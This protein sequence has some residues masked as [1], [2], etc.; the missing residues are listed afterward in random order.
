MAFGILPHA[1]VGQPVRMATAAGDPTGRAHRRQGTLEQ[2]LATEPFLAANFVGHGDHAERFHIGVV[3]ADGAVE[4]VVNVNLGPIGIEADGARVP[5]DADG[6]ADALR[7]AVVVVESLRHVHV[8]R[9]GVD[10]VELL[11]V[12]AQRRFPRVRDDVHVVVSIEGNRP[13]A[14]LAL[15]LLPQVAD[16]QLRENRPAG[17]E[18]GDAAADV[19]EVR[20]RPLRVEHDVAGQIVRFVTDPSI[21]DVPG[22]QTNRVQFGRE[23]L[24][25]KDRFLVGGQR[26]AP[27]VRPGLESARDLARGNVDLG[28]GAGVVVRDIGEL[29]VGGCDD[30]VRFVIDL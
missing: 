3:N 14:L 26:D 17:V 13:S 25:D 27:A 11:A 20:L 5:A 16:G 29:A 4:R 19:R 23:K 30:T 24:G 7:F 15:R 2:F 12:R 6:P 10:R 8:V 18:I 1:A 9:A 21:G 28:H 22:L